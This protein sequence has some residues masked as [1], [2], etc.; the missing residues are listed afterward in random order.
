M[1]V[2]LGAVPVDKI[3]G[4]NGRN[5]ALHRHSRPI[6]VCAAD[7]DFLEADLWPIWLGL[8]QLPSGSS[9]GTQNLD[10]LV[11]RLSTTSCYLHH[12]RTNRV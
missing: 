1:R 10:I 8:P 3:A 9:P 4:E 12:L 7:D 6:A 5:S 11:W 2:A